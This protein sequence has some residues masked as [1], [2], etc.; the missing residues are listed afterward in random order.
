MGNTLI[1]ISRQH[2]SGGT[3]VAQILAEKL[4]IW[5]YN[6]EILYIAADKIGYDSLDEKSMD[7]INYKKASKYMEGLSIM[8]GFAACRVFP[9]VDDRNCSL[10]HK[11]SQHMLDLP[12]PEK[13]LR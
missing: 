2:G 8:T 7:E 5:Y 3:K 4:G 11:K 9:D 13:P 1:T 12:H 6:R 10:C